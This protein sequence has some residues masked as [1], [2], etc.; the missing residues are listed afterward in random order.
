MSHSIYDNSISTVISEYKDKNYEENTNYTNI[1]FNK[2]LFNN[3]IIT[4]IEI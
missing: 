4:N 1:L 2:N 3:I